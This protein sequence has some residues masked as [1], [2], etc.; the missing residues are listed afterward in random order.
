MTLYQIGLLINIIGAIILCFFNLPNEYYP[1]TGHKFVT[2]KVASPEEVE[3]YKRHNRIRK[4]MA[5]IGIM[6]MTAGFILLFVD[7]LIKH[8]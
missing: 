1:E 4:Y 5:R 6:S 7:A 8:S 3:G 2:R